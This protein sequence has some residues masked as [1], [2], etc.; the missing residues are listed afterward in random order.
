MT[1]T[2][3]GRGGKEGI[4][5]KKDGPRGAL[6]T[7]IRFAKVGRG[8]SKAKPSPWIGGNKVRHLL[9]SG[10]APEPG[11]GGGG[12]SEGG[13]KNDGLMANEKI[14]GKSK[15]STGIVERLF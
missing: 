15:L 14:N 5:K 12:W 13:R 7:L 2:E 4:K 6:R 8:K 10:G 3:E 9:A 11:G 1:N